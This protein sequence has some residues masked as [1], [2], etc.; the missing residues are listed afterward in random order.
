MSISTMKEILR[1]TEVFK[2]VVY[3]YDLKLDNRR[4]NKYCLDYA[5]N[6]EK[7]IISNVGGYQSKNLDLNHKYFKS[8]TEF[9]NVILNEIS[10]NQFQFNQP[11]KITNMWFN[12]NKYKDYNRE[13]QHTGSV[14]SGVFYLDVP[15]NCGNINFINPLEMNWYYNSDKVK[16]YNI[17]NSSEYFF[18]VYKNV[19]YVF[20]SWLTHRVEPNLSKKDRISFSFNSNFI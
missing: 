18:P 14:L 4:L 11:V 15:K 10:L 8:I 5:K 12:I 13:H 6:N 2:T 7:S 17:L 1:A 20:P 9:I 16:N 3:S 19:L